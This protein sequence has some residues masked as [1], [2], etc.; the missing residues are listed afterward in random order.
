M[1]DTESVRRSATIVVHP[2]ERYPIAREGDVPGD[3]NPSR[4]KLNGFERQTFT[5]LRGNPVGNVILAN[6]HGTN[7][8][9]T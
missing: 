4:L 6:G 2:S 8:W 3:L 1:C 9:P 5:G 7:R